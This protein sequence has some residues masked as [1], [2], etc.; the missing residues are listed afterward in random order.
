MRQ[1]CIRKPASER[2]LNWYLPEGRILDED[3]H[4]DAVLV[5]QGVDGRYIRF[6]DPA[7]EADKV[8]RDK[9]GYPIHVLEQ[10]EIDEAEVVEGALYIVE[11][12]DGPVIPQSTRDQVHGLAELGWLYRRIRSRI[13]AK[14]ADSGA[15]TIELALC[16][17]LQEEMRR[18]D[19]LIASIEARR[20]G[21][22][23]AGSAERQDKPLALSLNLDD[24]SLS[25]T[26]HRLAVWVEGDRLKMR[27]M[28]VLVEGCTSELHN[29]GTL[30]K[31]IDS[32]PL[33]SATRGGA[34]LSLLHGYTAHGDPFISSF[35]SALLA[36]VSQ[37]FFRSLAAWIYHGELLDPAGEFFAQARKRNQDGQRD[38][39]DSTS[40]AESW[41]GRYRF[42]KEMLP[43]FLS[44]GFGKKVHCSSP[45]A[46]L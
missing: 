11:D 15:G 20:A 2:K 35:T 7:S 33:L 43:S 22:S 17:C 9:R 21:S 28:G 45:L 30:S 29:T 25:V 10:N 26:L 32:C 39:D 16:H 38:Q 14:L 13:D 1:G 18:Y 3:L 44:E 4:R 36:R 12:S 40:A 41:N 23:P 24:P 46:L 42:R 5:L 8:R 19:C 6:L 31:R 37:P 27:M 34:L